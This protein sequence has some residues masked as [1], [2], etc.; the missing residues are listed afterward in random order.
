VKESTD[1]MNATDITLLVFAILVGLPVAYG[2]VAA[3]LVPW[4]R[5]PEDGHFLA[6]V[7]I[8]NVPYTRIWHGMR[9]PRSADPLPADRA[10]I[11]VANHRSSCDPF[12]VARLTRRRLRFFMAREYYET[13]G[14]RWICDQLGAIPVNRDGNDLSAMRIALRHLRD[15]GALGVFPQGGIR[16]ADDSLGNAKNGVALLALKTGAPVLPVYIDGRPSFDD[17]LP[18]MIVPTRTKIYAGELLEL[19]HADGKPTRDDLDRITGQILAAIR[20][21]KP[22]TSSTKTTQAPSK[23]EA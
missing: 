13:F 1:P 20:D 11:V 15:G 21:L 8:V 10:C 17:A 3:A 7:R 2:L 12:L 16:E 6:W 9:V 18:G 19:K 5:G 4:V 14:L 22:G 23:A